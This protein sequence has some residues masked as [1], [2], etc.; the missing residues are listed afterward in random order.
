MDKKIGDQIEIQEVLSEDESANFKNT[1]LTVVGTI[2]SPLFI[3]RERGTSSLGSGKLI[4]IFM[5][6]KTI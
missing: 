4:I 3:S 5:L 6:Q 2:E 1:K